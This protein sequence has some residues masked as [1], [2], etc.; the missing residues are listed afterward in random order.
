MRTDAG[1]VSDIPDLVQPPVSAGL[2]Q[3]TGSALTV[4]F[5]LQESQERY[6]VFASGKFCSNI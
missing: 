1:K 6:F 4:G 5:S 3:L 2:L